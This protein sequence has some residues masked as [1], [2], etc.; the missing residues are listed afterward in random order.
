MPQA[1]QSDAFQNDAFQTALDAG[2][3]ASRTFTCTPGFGIVRE[4]RTATAAIDFDGSANFQAFNRTTRPYYRFEVNLGPLNRIE[5]ESLSAFH[6]FHKGA[7]TFFWDGF[8]YNTV[9][10]YQLAAEGN[11]TSRLFYLP[12]RY[13]GASSIAIQTLRPST[14][15]TS[16]WA[17]SS[18]NGWPWSLNATIGQMSFANSSNTIPVSGDDIC[19]AYA[20]TYLCYFDPNGLRLEAVGGGLYKATLKLNEALL[21]G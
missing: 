6:A 20:C 5:A 18:A 1:F 21:T 14:G 10:T 2:G 7:T 19:A 9:N 3:V 4:A 13:I 12:N 11:G 16:N 8:P 15:A 17:T